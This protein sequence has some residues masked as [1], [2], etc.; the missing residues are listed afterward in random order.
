V[1]TNHVH[2]DRLKKM[3]MSDLILNSQIPENAR[4]GRWLTVT[5]LSAKSGKICW[6]DPNDEWSAA[7]KIA[8][9]ESTDDS[10]H[11]GAAEHTL[12]TARLFA[13]APV[14]S[15]VLA[16]WLQDPDA[17]VVCLLVMP[18]EFSLGLYSAFG[19]YIESFL[20]DSHNI[21]IDAGV[22]AIDSPVLIL[23]IK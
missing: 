1:V 14:S 20:G 8:Y 4:W 7:F 10:L 17:S 13:Q 11:R 19:A 16:E 3:T 23:N 12:R 5:D 9:A 22:A 18:G 21:R 6:F 15:S 2:H